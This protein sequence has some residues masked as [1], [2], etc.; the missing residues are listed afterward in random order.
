MA[1]VGSSVPL[2]TVIALWSLAISALALFFSQFRG[3]KLSNVVGPELKIYYPSDGG[4]GVYVPATFL[5]RSSKT[6]TVLS[7]GISI[8]RKASPD[9]RFFMEWRFFVALDPDLS[10][11]LEEPAHALAIPGNSSATKII[12][13]T[14]RSASTP[15]LRMTE[16]E[17]ELVFHYW[18]GS[19]E[20]PCNDPHEFYIDKTTAEELEGYRVKK[21]SRVVDLLLDKKIASNRLLTSY[22]SKS[23][24]G[25]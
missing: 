10:Y 16:G 24:L 19:D 8:L 11:R 17:Y 6:G 22:E 9:E 15:E 13:L 7:C 4:L 18:P 5:N 23:L 25:F 14:W 20:K 12:W 2:S 21:Q 3:P 1:H